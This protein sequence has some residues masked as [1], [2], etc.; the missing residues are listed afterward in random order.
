VREH[1]LYYIIDSQNLDSVSPDGPGATLG[2]Y[3]GGSRWA[4]STRAPKEHRHGPMHTD[5]LAGFRL[6]LIDMIPQTASKIEKGPAGRYKRAAPRS[7]SPTVF[8]VWVA[9]VAHA[10][11]TWYSSSLMPSSLYSWLP[12]GMRCSCECDT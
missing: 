12:P 10:F 9:P 1:E 5:L 7:A 2:G 3:A 11:H 8:P 6:S 4:R